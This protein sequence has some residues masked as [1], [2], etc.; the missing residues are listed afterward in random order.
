MR[1]RCLAVLLVMAVTPALGTA[2]TTV[3]DATPVAFPFTP[4]PA[5]CRAAPRPPDEVLALLTGTP[6]AAASPV[7]GLPSAVPSEDQLP[8]G[9]PADAATVA[10][11]VTTARELIACNNA[12]D[13][14]R[15]FA[16]YT[17]DFIREAFGGD[18]TAGAQLAAGLASPPAPLPAEARTELLAVRGA[19][20]LADGR[21]GAVVED[22]DPRQT[23]VFFL[24]FAR[25]GDRWL[26][27][28]QIGVQ[29]T[30]T[31]T[32]SPLAA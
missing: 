25:T 29:A 23:V 11:I 27:D 13:L 31:P 10:G 19:R 17:D 32:A 18:P 6:V 30:A 12:G 3:Q 24:I 8:A 16:F 26:V 4:D 5:E 1:P 14:S 2:R 15:V 22:R 9:S 28:G 21:I 7:T 20:V